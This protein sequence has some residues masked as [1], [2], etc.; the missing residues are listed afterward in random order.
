MAFNILLR[1]GGDLASG[2]AL[3]LHRAGLHVIIT[4]LPQPLAVRRLVSF[5][6]AVY[7]GEITVEGIPARRIQD[8]TDTLNILLTLAKGKLPVLIDPE[9]VAIEHL[10]PAIVI[11]ARMLKQPVE[12]DKHVV[13]LLIGLGPGFTAGVNCHAAIE[14]NR[15]PFLGR[16]YWQGAPEADTGLPEAVNERGAERVLRAPCDG[17]LATRV[18]ICAL[19]AAGQLVAEVAGQP[20][21]APFDGALRGLL[22][23]G[24]EVRRDMKIGDVDPRG[25]PAL[26]GLVSE[27]ALAIGGGVLEAILARPE[28]R[29]HLW[30]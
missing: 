3:R 1:G 5:A 22:H 17:T 8:P 16:V 21:Y 28:L 6:E 7:G 10:H 26:C 29:R 4:E 9:A 25:N 12:L 27:K 15:G 13:Q 2:V 30:D 14:T 20:V 18:E 24:L 23:A 19:L 11:D